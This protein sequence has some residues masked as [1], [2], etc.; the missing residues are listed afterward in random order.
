MWVCGVQ[1]GRDLDFRCLSRP[2]N[3]TRGVALS[4][5]RTVLVPI[6]YLKKPIRLLQKYFV[7][8][9]GSLASRMSDDGGILPQGRIARLL[10]SCGMSD[11]KGRQVRGRL[12]LGMAGH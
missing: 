1:E 8:A 6:V 11:S 9:K 4:A 7:A 5:G 12:C 2:R 3:R 10:S